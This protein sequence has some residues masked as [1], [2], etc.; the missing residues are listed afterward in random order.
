MTTRRYIIGVHFE[1]VGSAADSGDVWYYGKHAP[2][3][4]GAYTWRQGLVSLP[5]SVESSV[6]PVTSRVR[7]SGFEFVLSQGCGLATDL[8]A[9]QTTTSYTLGAAVSDSDTTLELDAALAG[10]YVYVGEETILVGGLVSG[11]SIS[12]G[13]RSRHGSTARAHAAGSRVYTRTPWWS[14]RAV[15]LVRHDLDTGVNDII[16]RGYVDAKDGIE[17][18]AAGARISVRCSEYFGRWRGATVNREARNLN[19]GSLRTDGRRIFG[20]LRDRSGGSR[21]RALADSL[22]ASDRWIPVQVGGAIVDSF[23]DA[24]RETWTL[25]VGPATCRLA[26]TIEV[27]DIEGRDSAPYDGDVFELVVWDRLGDARTGRQVTP[28]LTSPAHHPIRAAMALLISDGQGGLV[29]PLSREWGLG[30]D[31]ID[32]TTLEGFVDS[33][34]ELVLDRL[35]LGWG[36][37]DVKPFDVARNLLR[38]YGY[39]WAIKSDGRLSL[40]RYEL[41]TIE[42]YDEARGA[43]VAPYRGL[44]KWKSASAA[45]VSEIRATVGETP[46]SRGV[47]S[48]IRAS[49]EATRAAILSSAER[50][51]YDLSMVRAS[52]AE[53]VALRLADSTALLHFGAPRLRIRVGDQALTGVTYDLGAHVV[54]DASVVESAWFIDRDGERVPGGDVSG[55]VDFVGRLISRRLMLDKACIYEIELALTAYRVGTYSRLRAP[56]ALITAADGADLGVDGDVFGGIAGDY[57]HFEVGDEVAWWT[58]AGEAGDSG[59]VRTITAIAEVPGGAV[60][61]VSSAWGTDP[62]FNSILRLGRYDQYADAARYDFEDHPFTFLAGSDDALGA[63]SDSAHIYGGGLGI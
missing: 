63:A 36:G 9:P 17:T 39:S 50:I 59:N 44:L 56:S 1:G 13:T 3:T 28:P 24:S 45:G 37:A 61:T 34:P 38:A 22:L 19:T 62:D 15:R 11:S 25:N 60:I 43:S 31:H 23:W 7:T 35:V 21:P 2:P 52:S 58:R 47:E 5:R 57:S 29:T 8:L 33:T 14:A 20:T 53:D 26:S 55:R 30:I 41:L 54:I 46:W 10:A 32:W 4:G 12:G 6:D 27:P 51:D 49:G 16:W 40:M 48:L 18:D 42:Q